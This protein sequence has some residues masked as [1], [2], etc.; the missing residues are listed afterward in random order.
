LIEIVD[1]KIVAHRATQGMI[2]E[3]TEVTGIILMIGTEICQIKHS[4]TEMITIRSQ[5]A[6]MK[7]HVIPIRTEQVIVE[8]DVTMEA[9]EDS[10]IERIEAMIIQRMRGLSEIVRLQQ[11]VLGNEMG[12]QILD[13]RED[14]EIM[15]EDNVI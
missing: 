4:E 6:I 9:T 11:E 13:T 12:I 14:I 1:I 8:I 7:N 3:K 15:R 5:D 2:G 10:M